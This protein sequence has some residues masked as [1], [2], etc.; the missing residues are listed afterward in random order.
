VDGADFRAAPARGAGLSF[1]TTVPARE[2]CGP[3]LCR[4]SERADA[5]PFGRVRTFVEEES[6]DLAFL[7]RAS[8]EGNRP[9]STDLP[10]FHLRDP[11]LAVSVAFRDLVPAPD[12]RTVVFAP[13]ASAKFDGAPRRFRNVFRNGDV[14]IYRVQ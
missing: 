2:P 1:G 4:A 8:V 9:L 11:L 3:P 6:R 14:A 5:N 10:V 12:K 7:L 13:E